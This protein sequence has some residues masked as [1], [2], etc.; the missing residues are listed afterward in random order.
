MTE[1][2][3]STSRSVPVEFT[4]K[5]GE[6]FKLWIVNLLLTIV[7]L[8]I[9]GAW[10]KVRNTQ[11]MYGH[12]SI[13]GHRL[14]YLATPMQ[15]L[16][17]RAI[18]MLIFAAYSILA[19]LSPYLAMVLTLILLGAFPWLI[20]QGIRFSMRMTAYRN[21]RF[22]FAGTYGGAL[23]NFI[24]YPLIGVLT[25]YLAFPW[26]LKKMHQYIYDN[27][28]YGGKPLEL[29][30]STGFYYGVLLACL[31]MTVVIVAVLA[32]IFAGGAAFS[33]G[34]SSPSVIMAL[35]PAIFIG[36]F[37][38]MYGVAGFF[39]ANLH[40]H[41]HNNLS[42]EEV[43]SFKSSVSVPGYMLLTITNGLLVMVTLGLAYPVTQIR[44]AAYI[45]KSME[46]VVKPGMEELINTVSDGDSAMGEEASE[47]FD[48][49][50]SLI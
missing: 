41:I 33:S 17:G 45:S 22:S 10:A 4:G 35:A 19:E 49:E 34:S 18:A 21:V 44:K 38:V 48:A 6:Y 12:T 37:L 40:N 25:F 30:N 14:R 50:V 15:I 32:A 11:Y 8:G 43:V 2:V 26:A 7:T 5:S 1:F 29:K 31:G 46:V 36:Y 20:V 23:L 16:K 24:V 47:L 13:D 3:S 27:I 9:Y 28:T 42:M 39:K